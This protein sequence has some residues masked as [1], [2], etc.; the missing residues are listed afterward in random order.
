MFGTF[1]LT[2]KI[3]HPIWIYVGGGVATNQEL[4]EF[5]DAN[6]KIEYVPNKDVKVLCFNPEAGVK[7]K[8]GFLVFSYG[9]N[10]PFSETFS[11]PYMHQ[12]GAAFSLNN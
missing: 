1:G 3:F 6:G 5:K 2:K 9:V 7:V 4:R 10:K 11:Q 12:F 8:L